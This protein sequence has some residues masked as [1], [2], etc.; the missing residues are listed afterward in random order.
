MQIEAAKRVFKYKGQELPDL[1]KKLSPEEIVKAYAETHPELTNASPGSP[2]IQDDGTVVYDI[3]V[4][5]GRFG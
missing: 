2:N 1:D 4:T 3:A 5:T